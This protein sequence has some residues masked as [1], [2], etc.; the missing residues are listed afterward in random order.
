MQIHPVLL[1]SNPLLA[2][3]YLFLE[4][5]RK[6]SGQLK[7]APKL[8]T[9]ILVTGDGDFIPLIQY[10]DMNQGCQVEVISFGK[11]IQSLAL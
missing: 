1:R 7:L 11:S 8:D 3:E 10:L 4:T 2:L 6:R 9:V 5:K